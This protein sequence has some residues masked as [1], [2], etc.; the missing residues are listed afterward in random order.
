MY[1]ERDLP[2]ETHLDEKSRTELNSD[3]N[4]SSETYE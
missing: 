4:T 2:K 1:V 3:L